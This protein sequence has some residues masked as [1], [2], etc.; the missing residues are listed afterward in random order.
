MFDSLR[1]RSSPAVVWSVRIILT[2]IA[3]SFAVWG[4]ESYFTSSAI[5]EGVASVNGAKITQQ[6]FAEALRS[7]QDTVRERNQGK[8]DA[9][10]FRSAEFKQSVLDVMINRRLLARDTHKAKMMVSDAQLVERIHALPVFQV[11]GKFSKEVFESQARNRGYSPVGMEEVLREDFAVQDYYESIAGTAVIPQVAVER[12]IKITEQQREVSIASV[13]ADQFMAGVNIEPAQTKK[14]YDA[15]LDEFKIPEQAKVEYVVYSAQKL[16]QDVEVKPEEIATLYKEREAEFVQK[17]Q[18]QASHILIAADA[19]APDAEKAAAR[20][21]AEQLL[22]QVKANPAKFADLA[23]QHSQ[24]PAT[25]VDG[26]KLDFVTKEGLLA[27]PFEDALFKMQKGEIAGPVETEF[28]Y[29]II[30][31]DEVDPQRG[32]SLAEMSDEL[33][34]QL[35][36][37]KAGR[38]FAEKAEM[39]GDLVYDQAKGIK[40][41]AEALKL[42]VKQ[43]DWISKG[44]GGPDPMLNN[45]KLLDAIFSAGVLKEKRATEPVEVEPNVLVAA[46]VLESKPSTTKA[47]D[48]VASEIA[49]RLK[50]EEAGKQAIKKGQA[51]LAELKAG[52][53]PADLVWSK[54]SLVSRQNFGDVSPVFQKTVFAADA[55]KVPA[56]A[57]QDDPAGGYALIRISKLVDVDKIDDLRRAPAKARLEDVYRG[58]TEAAAISSLRARGTINVDTAALV[59]KGQ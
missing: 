45:P 4:V 21:K 55:Q 17:E 34:A 29:H 27:A 43:S 20:N 58:A 48:S 59:E 24:D 57:G 56:Y 3:M 40:G 26:G 33:K 46:R 11:D 44:M 42:E 12:F 2:L 31:L 39:F 35:Q 49:D 16:A 41:A 1:D 52:K 8:V 7:Q 6:E 5:T 19:K 25:A 23:K 54:A 50:R 18:R 53:T 38:Q 15:N 10:L 37:R 36:K 32:K 47:Y 51:L 14:Y 13:K 22:A 30:R 9:E 28:G